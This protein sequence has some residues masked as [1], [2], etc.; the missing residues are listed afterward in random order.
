[1]ALPEARKRIKTEEWIRCDMRVHTQYAR[2]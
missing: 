1:M 2:D